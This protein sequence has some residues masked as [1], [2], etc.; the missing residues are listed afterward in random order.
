MT[1]ADWAFRGDR[2]AAWWG[3]LTSQFEKIWVKKGNLL[4]IKYRG[5]K[6]SKKIESTTIIVVSKKKAANSFHNKMQID[7]HNEK[8]NFVKNCQAKKNLKI[9]TKDPS[10]RPSQESMVVPSPETRQLSAPPERWWAKGGPSDSGGFWTWGGTFGGAYF[11]GVW[12]VSLNSGG[13]F[14]VWSLA[15]W[16]F[17]TFSSKKIKWDTTPWN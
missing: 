4:Q 16:M 5:R 6:L 15:A 1:M 2:S 14:E 7:C 17:S 12:A 11:P 3:S 9:P 13:F 10:S 8:N